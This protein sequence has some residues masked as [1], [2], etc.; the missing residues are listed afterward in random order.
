MSNIKTKQELNEYINADL[1]RYTGEVS[2][3]AF[4]RTYKFIPGFRFTYWMR[5]CDYLSGRNILTR[6]SFYRANRRF[7]RLRYQFGFDIEYS[8]RIGKGL[9]FGHWGGVVIHPSVT[10][11]KNCNI[12]HQVTLGVDCNKG[13]GAIPA[14]GDKVYIGPGSKI[15]GKI[16]LGDG[17]AIGANSVVNRNVPP[18]VTAAGAPAKVVSQNDSSSY[19]TNTVP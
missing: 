1:F 15:F 4:K 10:I 3:K 14:V 17:C 7:K 11:G 2:R 6:P 9:Y 13:A 16:T 8:T 18:G 5:K 19:V 12:S